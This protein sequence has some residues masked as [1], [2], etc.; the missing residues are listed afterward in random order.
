[1]TNDQQ[2]PT[3]ED[4]MRVVKRDH[5]VKSEMSSRIAA[6]VRENLELMSIVQE[7]QQDL[8]DLR[9]GQQLLAHTHTHATDT[10]P[11]SNGDVATEDQPR[12]FAGG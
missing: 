1:M 5:F 12:L 7:Q 9:E 4:L 2:Q 11:P 10:R 3:S 6:L 8:A